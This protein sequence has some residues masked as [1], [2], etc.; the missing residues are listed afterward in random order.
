VQLRKARL[1]QFNAS[2]NPELQLRLK[3]ESFKALGQSVD[4]HSR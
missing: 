1:K 4:N 2:T 3:P